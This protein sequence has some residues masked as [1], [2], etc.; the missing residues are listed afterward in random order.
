MEISYRRFGITCRSCIRGSR[1]P[2]PK[3]KN[4]SSHYGVH[5]GKNVT[6]EDWTGSRLETSVRNYHYSLRNDP[7]ELSSHLLRGESLKSRTDFSTVLRQGCTVVH[8]SESV[9]C[10]PQPAVRL[11]RRCSRYRTQL[12]AAAPTPS[13]YSPTP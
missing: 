1:T 13:S 11:I 2:P 8:L 12:A 9:I 4:L 10:F 5:I 3:K 7:E 6:T